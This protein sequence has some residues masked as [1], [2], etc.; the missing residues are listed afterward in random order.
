MRVG[1]FQA[2]TWENTDFDNAELIFTAVGGQNLGDVGAELGK[3]L[4]P[5]K[6]YYIV[7]CENASRPAKTLGGA[8]GLPRVSVSEATVFC[9]TVE[10]GGLDIRSENYPY[11]QCDAAPLEGF[12]LGIAG[13]KKTPG[14]GNFLTRKL[15]TYNAAACV[16]AYIGSLYG[17]SSFGEAANAPRI[18]SLLARNYEETGRAFGYGEDDQ[19]EFAALSKR[20]FTDKSIDDSVARNARDPQRKL[21]AGERIMGPMALICENG[22]DAS[23]LVM[24][25]A[26]ALIYD[27]DGE[28]EWRKLKEE[29]GFPGILTD[30]AGLEPQSKLYKQILMKTGELQ[31]LK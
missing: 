23:A 29:K 10:D 14:F 13:V 9:T 20:K 17:Y 8:I 3:R 30:L 27:A 21:A 19:R 24:T 18:L 4:D 26:A 1:N 22:G 28:E 12:N 16:I 11:L 25:A 31:T 6:R 5:E 7:T 15:Y 2:F